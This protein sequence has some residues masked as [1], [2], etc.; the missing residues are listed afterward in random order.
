MNE[1]DLETRLNTGAVKDNTCMR[2]DGRRYILF[3]EINKT[4]L[5]TEKVR[6]RSRAPRARISSWLQD[7]D[8][9]TLDRRL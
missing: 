7:R 3:P 2:T 9:Q 8:S 5:D 4:I 6:S 1:F